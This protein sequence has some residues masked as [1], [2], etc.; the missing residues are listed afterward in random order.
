MIYWGHATI[1]Y[2]FGP[3]CRPEVTSRI[4]EAVRARIADAFFVYR[5][6]LDSFLTNWV[7]WQMF[8]RENRWVCGISDVYKSNDHFC[9]DLE[10]NFADFKAFANGDPSF[11]GSS[12]GTVLSF[13][14][15]VE[16]TELFLQAPVFPVRFEDFFIDPLKEFA[17]IAQVMSVDLDLSRTQVRP[18]KSKPYRFLAVREKVPQFRDLI[19]GLDAETRSRLEKIGYS[20]TA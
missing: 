2:P 13:R 20:V 4:F 14:Q 18:P 3:R 10:R 16:E 6:P 1:R 9:D 19:D 8:L 15:F 17:K 12:R 5:H 11:C 7:W